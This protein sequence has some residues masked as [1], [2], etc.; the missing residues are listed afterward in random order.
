VRRPAV[1]VERA[2]DTGLVPAIVP[3]DPARRRS[4][5][6]ADGRLAGTASLMALARGPGYGKIGHWVAP[7][8]RGRGVATFAE[9]GGLR[10]LPRGVDPGPP[11]LIVYLWEAC[12]SSSP[13][14]W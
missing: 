5:P 14:A 1:V 11:S 8:A 6:A 12:R 9:T 10:T 7:S 2:R 4:H 3:P 13:T